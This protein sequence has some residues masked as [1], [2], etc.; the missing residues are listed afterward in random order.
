VLDGLLAH[1]VRLRD[2]YGMVSR[3]MADSWNH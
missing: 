3:T 2:E 1:F